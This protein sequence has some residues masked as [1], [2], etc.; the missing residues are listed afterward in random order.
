MKRKIVAL[1]AILLMSVGA[2]MAHPIQ[3]TTSCGK[4][5]YIESENYDNVDDLIHDVLLIDSVLC[6]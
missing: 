4:I 1:S 2:A 6:L 5:I 3:I